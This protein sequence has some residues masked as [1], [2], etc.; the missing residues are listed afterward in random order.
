MN[1]RSPA[2]EEENAGSAGG[3]AE[4]ALAVQVPVAVLR[5]RRVVLAAAAEAVEEERVVGAGLVSRSP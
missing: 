5:C 3:R 4:A 1:R 2:S